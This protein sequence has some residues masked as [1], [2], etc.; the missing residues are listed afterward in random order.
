[1]VSS[2]PSWLMW[3]VVII[4]AIYVLDI[5]LKLVIY[6]ITKWVDTWSDSE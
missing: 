5:I 2:P 3:I 4:T 1:M 6:G